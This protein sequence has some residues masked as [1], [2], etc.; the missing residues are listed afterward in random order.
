MRRDV[1]NDLKDLTYIS[2]F[3][4]SLLVTIRRDLKNIGHNAQ[5]GNGA[6]VAG[7]AS[8]GPLRDPSACL[9]YADSPEI[10]AVHN[11][12]TQA[13]GD[14]D[15]KKPA[16]ARK[17]PFPLPSRLVG[18]GLEI[19]FCSRPRLTSERSAGIEPSMTGTDRCFPLFADMTPPAVMA[20][21]AMQPGPVISASL[22][23]S[24]ATP[25]RGPATAGNYRISNSGAPVWGRYGCREA[26]PIGAVRSVA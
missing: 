3:I 16:I 10:T 15:S 25:L 6:M 20:K 9:L 2:S 8:A 1:E 7:P 14:A 12:K 11:I 21:P 18:P 13:A 17:R 26:G 22:F 24:S 5:R 23:S 19:S 4:L